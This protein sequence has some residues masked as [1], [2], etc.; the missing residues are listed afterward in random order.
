MQSG[1]VG[2]DRNEEAPVEVELSNE[3]VMT[4]NNL[5]SSQADVAS[6]E[7]PTSGVAEVHEQSQHE[8]SSAE[9]SGSVGIDS[10]VSEDVVYNPESTAI[11]HHTSNTF[12]HHVWI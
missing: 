6:H 9:Q 10:D 2:I 3:A 12:K 1:S 8:I 5:V 4:E 7:P 11:L